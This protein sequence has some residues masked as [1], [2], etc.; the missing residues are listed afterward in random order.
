MKDKINILGEEYHIIIN[1]ILAGKDGE[2]D[3][4]IKQIRICNSLYTIPESITLG[5]REKYINEVVRH[6]IMHA[7]FSEAGIEINFGM[8]NEDTV[9]WIVRMYPK[10]KAIFEELGI[11]G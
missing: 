2:C 3:D 7:V 6:E 10:M 4:S 1:Q 9:N 8:H 11:E 5:N